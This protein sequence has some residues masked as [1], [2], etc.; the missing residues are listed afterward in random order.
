MEGPGKMSS[1][2]EIE[3]DSQQI[4]YLLLGSLKVC[5]KGSCVKG[6]TMSPGQLPSGG[7]AQGK[8]GG[9]TGTLVSL[10]PASPHACP[11]P[12]HSMPAHPPPVPPHACPPLSSRFSFAR[13]FSLLYLLCLCIALKTE[14]LG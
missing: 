1:D 2:W 4:W 3:K 13:E 5:P 6:C 7:R 8:G 12:P 10:L 11:L 9:D 14:Q